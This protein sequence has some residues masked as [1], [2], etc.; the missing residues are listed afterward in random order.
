MTAADETL[1]RDLMTGQEELRGDV[2]AIMGMV[3][4]R[5]R[6]GD[7]V[8]GRLLDLEER[9]RALEL[10]DAGGKD[11]PTHLKDHEGRIRSLENIRWQILAVAFLGSGVGGA[12]VWILTTVVVTTG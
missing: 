10:N 3:K 6:H 1:L 2:K 4:E 7:G 12:I 5:R 9:I 8:D 11:M